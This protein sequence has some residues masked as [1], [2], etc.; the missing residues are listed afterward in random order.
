MRR[1]VLTALALAAAL[2]ATGTAAGAEGDGQTELRG[3]LEI[4]HGDDPGAP[5]RGSAAQGDRGLPDLHYFLHAAGG[6]Y[7]LYFDGDLPEA[8]T[9]DSVTVSGR[10]SQREVHVSRLQADGSRT[11]PARGGSGGGGRPKPPPTTYLGA[12]DL[13]ALAVTLDG[14]L[15]P[16]EVQVRQAGFTGA[17]S[18]AA[19]LAEVSF[20]LTTLRGKADGTPADPDRAVGDVLGVT[21]TS[22]GT[23]C[24][25]AGWAASARS[26]ATAKGWDLAGYE[27]ITYVLP[28]QSRCEWGGLGSIGGQ[29]TWLNGNVSEGTWSH[30]I[31]HN[32]TL[33]HART[34]ICL[35]DGLRVSM[36]GGCDFEEYGDP[37]DVMGDASGQRHVNGRNKGHLSWLSGANVVTGRSGQTYTLSALE[38]ATNQ[39]QVLQVARSSSSNLYVEL[40]RSTGFDAFAPNDDVVTGVLIRTGPALATNANSYLVDT[41]P[42][43]ETFLDAALQVGQGF[44]DT[45]SGVYLELLSLNPDGTATVRVESGHPALAPTATAAAGGSTVVGMPR[46]HPGGTAQDPDKD[47]AS[48][49]WAFASCPA[50]CPAIVSN[51]SGALA[52]GSATVPGPLYTPTA[53]GT[54]VLRLTVRDGTGASDDSTST[55]T[56]LGPPPP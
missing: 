15:P 22:T 26:A 25:Y 32:L 6:R 34:L 1:T 42:Y 20:G 19:Y 18:V 45:V 55:D 4:V 33:Y 50:T 30:E 23:G 40:R 39:P 31:G 44:V 2:A 37:F 51:E 27:H 13:L 56:V 9:G 48:Y 43:T 17:Q 38:T 21:I 36:A 12:R 16:P 54:Y 52:A 35:R 47:L 53:G 8:V 28:H 14:A 11:A 29:S 5:Q 49:S 41:A 7:E 46:A 3:R 24:D 10:V